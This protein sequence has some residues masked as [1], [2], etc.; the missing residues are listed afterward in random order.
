MASNRGVGGSRQVC[1]GPHTS[2]SGKK[3]TCCVAMPMQTNLH[4]YQPETR[5]ESFVG[6]GV[7]FIDL[8][9]PQ[10]V[11]NGLLGSFGSIDVQDVLHLCHFACALYAPGCG[12]LDAPHL[13]VTA[14]LDALLDTFEHD[15]FLC[16]IFED[17]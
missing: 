9:K 4:T 17:E 15:T 6:L 2:I 13:V 7:L 10:K 12:T 5:G 14:Y 8:T 3:H 11:C 1:C 16:A